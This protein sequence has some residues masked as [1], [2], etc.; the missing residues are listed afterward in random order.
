MIIVSL[1]LFVLLAL[2]WFARKGAGRGDE[3]YFLASRKLSPVVTLL[4]L[5][6]T[7]FSAFTVFGFSGQGYATGF[8]YYPQMA[9]GTGLMATM[10]IVLGLPVHGLGSARR[11][12]SP[13][14]VLTTRYGGRAVGTASFAVM[15]ALT[16]PYLAMQ[17][18]AAGYALESLFGIPYAT[19]A[20]LTVLVMVLYTFRSGLRGVA[21]TDCFQGLLMPLLMGVVLLALLA[22]GGGATLFGELAATRPDLFTRSQAYSPGIWLGYMLLWVWADPMFPQLFQR[23][24]AS[25]GR[26][27]L[28][29]SARVYPLVTGVLFL[30][31]VTLGVIARHWIPELPEGVGVDR[32]LP[33]LLARACPGVLESLLLTA[34]LAAL[35]STMDSQLLT[36]SSMFTRDVW[37]PLSGEKA[38]RWAGKALV[39]VLAAGGLLLSFRPPESFLVL[40]RETFTGLA[41]LF[42]VY[43][44]TLYWKKASGVGAFSGI[45][46]GVVLTALFHLGVL[47]TAFT[48][49]VVFVVAGAAIAFVSASLLFPDGSARLVKSQ[50]P[51]RRLVFPGIIM[52]LGWGLSL[53]FLPEGLFLHLPWWVWASLALCVAASFS[54]AG[55]GLWTPKLSGGIVSHPVHGGRDALCRSSSDAPSPGGDHSR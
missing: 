16:L 31:P 15:A 44:G 1:Y 11:L 6:A 55:L 12:V 42:P 18:M 10:F 17:P 8:Q 40:A 39:L 45:I 7:N 46:A 9:L 29:L 50:F 28:A 35:M 30:M 51:F 3:A 24:F 2:G 22:R 43:L 52:L 32:I 34:G 38:P 47:K 53:P 49:P 4:T 23:F 36:L 25:T 20:S 48:L 19:G 21:L 14:E 54:M 13:S 5:S 27:A 26:G 41:A 37:E 33:L